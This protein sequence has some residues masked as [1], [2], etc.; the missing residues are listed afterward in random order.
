MYRQHFGFVEAEKKALMLIQPK[1]RASRDALLS[2]ISSQEQTSVTK[3]TLTVARPCAFQRAIDE[4][5]TLPPKSPKVGTKR[6]F[7][8]YTIKIQITS[9][10]LQLTLTVA[11]ALK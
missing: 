6:D 2:T 3:L 9:K 5:Y 8:V 1:I 7:A 4:P 10:N 11:V